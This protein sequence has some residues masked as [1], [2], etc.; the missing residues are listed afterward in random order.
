MAV[1]STALSR[2]KLYATQS[3]VLQPFNQ[4]SGAYHSGDVAQNHLIP[5]AFP[6]WQGGVF[7]LRFCFSQ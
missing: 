3:L 5:P 2:G 1:P 6:T 7:F 4:Y